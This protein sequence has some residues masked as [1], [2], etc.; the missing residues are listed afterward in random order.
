M[1]EFIRECLDSILMQ[2]LQ[3]IE[4]I[5]IDDGSTDQT[6]DI[7]K[8]YKNKLNNLKILHQENQGPGI[9]R[10]NGICAAVGEY[11]AFMDADDFYPSADTLEKMYTTSKRE[12]A[13][14]CGGSGCTFRNG[15]YTYD[16]FRKGFTFLEDGW[17]K[18]EEFPIINGYWRFIYK[19]A[20]IKENHIFFPDYLRCE[21]PPFF[22]TAIAYA[23]HVYCMKEITYVYRKEHKQVFFTQR[24]ALDY[25]KG[26]R[27]SLIISKRAKMVSIYHQILNELQGE[28]S[29]LMYLYGRHNDEMRDIIHQINEIIHDEV[30]D[31]AKLPLLKE[32]KEIAEYIE[33]AQEEI[34]CLLKELGNEKKVL[35][36]GAGTVGKQVR[37]FLEENGIA[38]ESFVV[39]N[40]KQNADSLDG[41][42][43]RSIDDYLDDKDEC[44]VII[45]TFSYLHREIVETLRKKEFKK[46]YTLSLEKF[47]LYRGEVAH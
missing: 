29:A 38:I 42:Q 18:K 41:L 35:I 33:N 34:R 1:G 27:D 13:E 22:M 12:K 44:M 25:A 36:Y 6:L 19:N 23:G 28:L 47:H 5:C 3:E 43:I 15:I 7:L 20:F 37:A 9:A 11:L 45:A 26:M 16:G 14:I 31:N 17:I 39:S 10:N 24:K 2:T 46:V 8:E 4:I 21:D 40:A 32:G 30:T